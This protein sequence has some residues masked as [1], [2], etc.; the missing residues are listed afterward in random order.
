[1]AA[2][3]FRCSVITTSSFWV[4]LWEANI[5]RP[6]QTKNM[7]CLRNTTLVNSANKFQCMSVPLEQEIFPEPMNCHVIQLMRATLKRRGDE[8]ADW[9][10]WE[11]D[12]RGLHDGGSMGDNPQLSMVGDS[13]NPTQGLELHTDLSTF[14][15]R[16]P[17]KL[18]HSGGGIAVIQ[19]K[20]CHSNMKPLNILTLSKGML[21]RALWLH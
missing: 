6:W 16:L 9:L 13:S 20:E 18:R 1:M 10:Y 3:N 12:R 11:H 14:V 7:R 8:L 15:L 2:L 21:N 19:K 4:W 5:V 17:R